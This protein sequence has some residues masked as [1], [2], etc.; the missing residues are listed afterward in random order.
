MKN[1][2]MEIRNAPQSISQ[3]GFKVT[4]YDGDSGRGLKIKSNKNN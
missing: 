4:A 3:S 2:D 1:I